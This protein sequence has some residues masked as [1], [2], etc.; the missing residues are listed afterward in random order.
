MPMVR[1]RREDVDLDSLD[2]DWAFVDATTD[3]D[4]ARQDAEDPDTPPPPTEAELADAV[5]VDPPLVGAAVRAVRRRMGQSQTAFAARFGFALGT[6]R[7]REQGRR[8]EL[9]AA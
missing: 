5:F 4:I 2:V 7:Q 9:P 1:K 8:L 3:E 6:L